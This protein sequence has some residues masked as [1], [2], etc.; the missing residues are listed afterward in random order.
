VGA[1]ARL[2]VGMADVCVWAAEGG[3]LAVLRWAR[4]HDCPW[5][6]NSCV[7]AARAGQLEVLRWVRE[8]DANGEVWNENTVRA[9]AAGLRKQEVLT[10]LD[11]LTGP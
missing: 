11:E 5:N 2:P 3:H 1:G 4:E 6:T 7:G 10:W 8:N 9:Q